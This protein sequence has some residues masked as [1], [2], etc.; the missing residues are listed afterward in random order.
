MYIRAGVCLNPYIGNT[1]YT[2][3]APKKISF[4]EKIIIGKNID[5]VAQAP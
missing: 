4:Y 2:I 5:P 3:A 1:K